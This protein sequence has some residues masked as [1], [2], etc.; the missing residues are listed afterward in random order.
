MI[1]KREL[2]RL[3][4]YFLLPYDEQRMPSPFITEERHYRT[5]LVHIYRFLGKVIRF[6]IFFPTC[7]TL[8]GIGR[9]S[10]TY[11]QKLEICSS[12]WFLDKL[13]VLHVLLLLL[14]FFYAKRFARFKNQLKLKTKNPLSLILYSLSLFLYFLL[15]S[16]KTFANRFGFSK[17]VI[18][19]VLYYSFA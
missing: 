14:L 5:R 15:R 19:L 2:K 12:H 11:L 6:K 13:Y 17:S 8:I 1:T 18:L 9:K 4:F 16:S 7:L 10:P 3:V